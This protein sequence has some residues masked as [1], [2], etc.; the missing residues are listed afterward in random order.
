MG[1]LVSEASNALAVPWKLAF[2]VLG[3]PR[4]AS[5][6]LMILTASPNEAPGPRLKEM[7]LA[8]NWPRWSMASG[9]FVRST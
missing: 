7:V 3:M 5:T 9:V 8:G 1:S 2:T 6:W 4:L